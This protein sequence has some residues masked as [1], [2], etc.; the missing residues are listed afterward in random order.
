MSQKDLEIF[1]SFARR[2][3]PSDAGGHNN[4]GVF[5][6][7]K[8]LIPEAIQQFE[9]ALELDPKMQVAE[10]NLEIAYTDSG[11]YDRRVGELRERLRENPDDQNSRRELGKIYARLHYY[12][13]AIQEMLAILAKHPEDVAAIVQIGQAERGR[14]DHERALQWFSKGRS[15]GPRLLGNSIPPWG[16]ALQSR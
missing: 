1:R 2:I 7:R 12:D 11:Y 6:Y 13:Y 8:D 14:G 4:L 15:V 16:V 3:D 10:R 5:Y 9:K